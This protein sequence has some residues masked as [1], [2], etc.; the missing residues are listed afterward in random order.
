AQGQGSGPGEVRT[1]SRRFDQRQVTARAISLRI[2]A[3]QEIAHEHDYDERRYDDLL[4]GLGQGPGRDP[5]AR[6]ALEL[7]HVG[8]PDA[9]PRPARLPS[10]GPRSSWP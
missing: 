7:G 1:P 6:M 8:R 5:L 3:N 2:N 10:R 4:Q 9:V